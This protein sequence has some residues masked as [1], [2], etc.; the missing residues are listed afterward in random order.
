MLS[1]NDKQDLYYAMKASIIDDSNGVVHESFIRNELTYE[2]MLNLCFNHDKN[3]YMEA[4]ELEPIGMLSILNVISEAKRRGQL[5]GQV[6]KVKSAQA[7]H[8]IGKWLSNKNISGKKIGMASMVVA[9]TGVS[10]WY[11]YRKLRKQGID[12]KTAAQ[13]AHKVAEKKAKKT[14]LKRDRDTAARWKARARRS[15]K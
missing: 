10:A 12:K 7:A 9:L 3:V 15:S 4:E 13:A 1:P 5:T 2:Q 14:G 6:S 8:D 11:L